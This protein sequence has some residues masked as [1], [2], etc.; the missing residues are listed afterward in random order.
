MSLGGGLC[1]GT[2]RSDF[3]RLYCPDHNYCRRDLIGCSPRSVLTGR[4]PL[5]K[6]SKPWPCHRHV[7]VV[8]LRSQVHHVAGCFRDCQTE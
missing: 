4:L 8:A 6:C 2:P 5:S 1:D 3:E 7:D